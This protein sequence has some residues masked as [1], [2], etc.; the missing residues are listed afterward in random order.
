M[1][2]VRTPRLLLRAIDP[3]E[4]ARI[5]SGVAG[6][7]DA[8]APDF[9]FEGDRIAVGA[10]ARRTAQ[11]GEQRPFGHYL[12]AGRTDGLA[13]GGIGFRGHPTSG[14]VEVGYGLVPSARGRG[15]AAEAL[16]ALLAL[17]HENGAGVVEAATTPDNVASQ[18]TLEHTGFRVVETDERL[19]HYEIALTTH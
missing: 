7:E 3:D 9:P 14:R 18:R 17:A 11:S 1:N 13:I 2:D 6:P 15:Y 10:F 16:T 19:I 8:W 4:A 5:L 12:I